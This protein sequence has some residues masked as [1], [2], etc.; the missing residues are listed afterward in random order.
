[1]L[2]KDGTALLVSEREA[3]S[4]S[5]FMPCVSAPHKTSRCA[6]STYPCAAAPAQTQTVP[7]NMYP[8]LWACRPIQR[9]H[10]RS[11]LTPLLRVYSSMGRRTMCL[12]APMK[13]QPANKVA[14]LRFGWLCLDARQTA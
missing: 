8:W 14:V 12:K 6:W 11:C 13:E 3:G 7:G 5:S 9:R 2:F 4:N 1:M 10:T